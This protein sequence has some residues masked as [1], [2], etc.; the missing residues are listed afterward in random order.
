MAHV[1]SR[2]A[3]TGVGLARPKKAP[4]AGGRQGLKDYQA[5]AGQPGFRRAEG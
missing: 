3:G 1:A 5:E 4:W 2:E